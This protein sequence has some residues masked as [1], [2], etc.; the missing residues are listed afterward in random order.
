MKT[1]GL[2]LATAVVTAVV[3]QLFKFTIIYI[4][5][6]HTEKADTSAE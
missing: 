1:L 6:K 3:N 5:S 2:I 4:G